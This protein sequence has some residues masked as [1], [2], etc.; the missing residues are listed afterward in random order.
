MPHRAISKKLSDVVIYRILHIDD[1]AHRIAL[2]VAVGF[3]VAWTPTI[4]FQ[5]ALTIAIAAA[6]RANKVVGLPI[7]WI[8]NPVTA[9]PLYYY[10]WVI[11]RATTRGALEHG[12]AVKSALA[13]AIASLNDP[14]TVLRH[15]FDVDFWRTTG[16]KL[17]GFGMELWIGSVIIGLILGALSYMI[18]RRG[19]TY[20]RAH[21]GALLKR[22]GV[23]VA[24]GAE[25]SPTSST[26]QRRES[27]ARPDKPDSD[28]QSQTA[29]ASCQEKPTE[30][31][32]S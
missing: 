29:G 25:G 5:M 22:R 31:I 30:Q 14:L 3:F 19:V 8:S 15:L 20:Y 4:G 26:D 28:S 7:V 2:G 21:H 24:H 18:T 23:E 12:P 1:S 17:I 16:L 9:V 32:R 13:K 27:A 10:N 11:G 6:V